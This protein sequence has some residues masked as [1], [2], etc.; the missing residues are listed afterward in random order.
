MGSGGF[1][2][3][4]GEALV[5]APLMLLGLFVV[6]VLG[7]AEVF[8]VLLVAGLAVQEPA[9]VDAGEEVFEEVAGGALGV[10]RGQAD[11]DVVEVGVVLAG[12]FGDGLLEGLQLVAQG[13]G[14]EQEASR[15]FSRRQ[16]SL[17]GSS[18]TAA[19]AGWV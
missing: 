19:L 11:G 18:E 7:V 16:P 6:P 10:E 3:E 17:S 4:L 1:A 5:A 2:D 13:D 12:V 9:A 8:V 15:S 14:V